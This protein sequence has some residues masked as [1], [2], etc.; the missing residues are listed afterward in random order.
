MTTN[1]DPTGTPEFFVDSNIV[2]AVAINREYDLAIKSGRDAVTHA[3]ECGKLLLDAKQDCLHGEWVEWLDIN[4]SGSLRT[5][6]KFIRLANASPR[7]HLTGANLTDA[8]AAIATPRRPKPP[9]E[10]PVGVVSVVR[11]R[12]QPPPLSVPLFKT[13]STAKVLDAE[14]VDT[15]SDPLVVDGPKESTILQ[16][17]KKLFGTTD[18]VDRETDTL[19]KVIPLLQSLD[20]ARK[21]YLHH[22][23]QYLQRRLERCETTA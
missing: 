17:T 15:E 20:D 19:K 2:H 16:A 14:L 5:A 12:P 6:Q 9:P 21:G 13:R 7:T 3:A 22:V 10:K 18:I 23:I 8:L 1:S 4:F 11:P